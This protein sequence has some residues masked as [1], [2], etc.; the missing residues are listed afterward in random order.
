MKKG[1]YIPF[2]MLKIKMKT[3]KN[4]N[5]SL[6]KTKSKRRKRNEKQRRNKLEGGWVLYCNFT[7]G[8]FK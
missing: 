5:D 6:K 8:K 3:T 1:E 4:L 7:D 2:N